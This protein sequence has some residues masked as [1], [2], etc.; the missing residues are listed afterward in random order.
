MRFIMTVLAVSSFAISIWAGDAPKADQEGI[1]LT[2]YRE[3]PEMLQF[4]QNYGG[5]MY[6]HY[7][8][9]TGRYVQRLPG[10]G[11]VKVR[12]KMPLKEGLNVVRFQDVAASI[13]ATTV[14]VT[15]LTDPKNTFVQEQNFEFDLVNP[16]KIMQKYIDRSLAVVSEGGETKGVLMSFDAS[17][18]V[19]RTDNQAQPISVIAR[20]QNVR[21]VRF[22]SLPGG[23]ITRPTLVWHL[24]AKKKGDHLIQCTYHT[25]NIAWKADYTATIAA[26]EKHLELAA[27]V[28]MENRSGAAYPN[29]RLK[30]IAGDVHRVLPANMRQ[31]FNRYAAAKPGNGGRGRPQFKEKSFFEYHLYTLER[32]TD[33]EDNSEKQIEM[34]N[35]VTGIPLNK[36]LVYYGGRGMYNYRQYGGQPNQSR[37]FGLKTNTKVDIYLEFKNDK[38]KGL[39]IPLPAG[40]VRVYKRDPADKAMEFIGEDEVDHT[41]K[42]ENVRLRM[43]SAFDVTGERRQT[44]F[45]CKYNEHWINESFEIKI[46]NHKE[47]DVEV[48]VQED[49]YRWVNWSITESSH[50][51]TKVNSQRVIFPL[52]VAKDGETVLTYTVRYTW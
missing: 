38:E 1:S 4:Y 29:A 23:L 16:N 51:H 47:E 30:L 11:V 26:D 17:N 44:H 33:L 8:A 40:R 36:R 10:W 49:L 9:S 32:P 43:G 14:L 39:G 46:R 31:Q 3:S 24:G 27:W 41:P 25:G 22:S 5:N 15:S 20:H 21:E 50:K 19:L 12:R 2:V 13:D 42:G 7:D 48:L 52:K 34:F 28:T 45:E 37:D 35:P 18:L 6:R